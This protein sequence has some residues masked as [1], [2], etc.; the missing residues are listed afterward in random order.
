MAIVEHVADDGFTAADETQRT[1]GRHAQMM[2]RFTAQELADRR[3]QD[4]AP[5]GPACVRRRAGALELQFEALSAPVDRFA[6]ENR[7]PV[8]ELPGPLPEL[9]AAIAGRV[10]GH[11]RQQSIAGQ[12]GKHCG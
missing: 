2:H 8:A 4:R 10:A 1:R 6:E 9:V 7:A 11:A 5:V 12:R 3:A